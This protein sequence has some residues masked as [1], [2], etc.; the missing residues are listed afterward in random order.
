MMQPPS[1]IFL[2]GKCPMLLWYAASRHVRGQ[3]AQIAGGGGQ[4]QWSYGR[5]RQC[6]CCLIPANAY[7]YMRDIADRGPD[8]EFWQQVVA[9]SDSEGK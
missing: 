9:N 6:D 8:H 1:D 3:P 7:N 5:A 2:N 4:R